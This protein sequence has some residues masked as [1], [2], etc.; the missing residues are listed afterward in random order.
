MPHIFLTINIICL[1]LP[2]K[3][4]HFNVTN[5]LIGNFAA[6]K[7]S[8]LSKSSISYANIKF[9]CLCCILIFKIS[10]RL[11]DIFNF[12]FCVL[13]LKNVAPFL[14][15]KIFLKYRIYFFILSIKFYSVSLSFQ[16]I[17]L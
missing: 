4:L 6:L 12:F 11:I 7:L 13:F 9:T 1:F 3:E 16:Q 14:A 15:D 17:K 8:I 2:Q 5:Y 10:A